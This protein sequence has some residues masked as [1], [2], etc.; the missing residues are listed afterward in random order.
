M[1]HE[2]GYADDA[3]MYYYYIIPNLDLNFRLKVQRNDID[4]I[5]MTHYVPHN[6]VPNVHV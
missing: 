4:V 2:I 5:L 1:I 6:R 3:K